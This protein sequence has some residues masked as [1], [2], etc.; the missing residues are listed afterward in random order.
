MPASTAT[1]VAKGASATTPSVI[2]MISADRM[3]S[4]RTAPLIFAFSAATTSTAGSDVA[5]HQLGVARGVL[6]PTVQ[7]PVRE[8]LEALVAEI[9]AAEHEQRRHRPGQEGAD[10][11]RRRH[12]DGLVDER[13]LGD[14]PHDRQ[15]AAGSQ[16]GHLLGVEGEVVAEHARG[17]P[18]GDLREHGHVVEQRGDVVEEQEQARGHGGYGSGMP[19]AVAA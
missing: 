2:T 11:Q 17:L 7:E 3:K 4:V 13:A 6:R 15:L 14:R 9:G 10:G 12:Q 16:A 19:A 18:R 8:L 1:R 5:A